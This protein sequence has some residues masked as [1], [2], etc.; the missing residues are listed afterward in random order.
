MIIK[1]IESKRKET[2]RLVSTKISLDNSI[3]EDELMNRHLTEIERMLNQYFGAKWRSTIIRDFFGRTV[4]AW[5][6]DWDITVEGNNVK[7]I[8]ILVETLMERKG[9]KTISIVMLNSD[10]VIEREADFTNMFTWRFTRAR[11][12]S[13]KR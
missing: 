1:Q 2:V 11:P 3:F 5:F 4:F 13:A 6:K 10:K 8:F 12:K 9:R 7:T